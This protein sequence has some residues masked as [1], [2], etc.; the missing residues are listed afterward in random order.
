MNSV[1]ESKHKSMETTPRVSARTL[2]FNKGWFAVFLSNVLG[3]IVGIVL[4]FGV[5]Y[6]VQWN[7]E[8]KEIRTMMTLIRQEI[9]DNRTTFVG[10]NEDFRQTKELCELL[11]SSHWKTLPEDSVSHLLTGQVIKA[12]TV[13]HTAWDIFQNSDVIRNFDDKELIMA[14]SELYVTMTELYKWWQIYIEENMAAT[15]FHI[16][17]E[18][19]LG[20]SDYMNALLK[21]EKLRI[22]MEDIY[23]IQ[24]YTFEEPI[25]ATIDLADYTLHLINKDSNYQSDIKNLN[26]NLN[27][28][29]KNKEEASEKQNIQ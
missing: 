25:A 11:L 15:T 29:H 27:T 9:A 19:F 17:Q 16:K 5:S 10:M 4:T 28:F 14:I 24:K 8:K 2:F 7:S 1:K 20:F 22:F 3:V 13:R 6:F 12:Y 18:E 26:E 23:I 21:I